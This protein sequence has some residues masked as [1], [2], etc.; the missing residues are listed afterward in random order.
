MVGM[1]GEKIYYKGG[2]WTQKMIE[3]QGEL[4]IDKRCS[5]G[6]ILKVAKWKVWCCANPIID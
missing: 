4:E 5:A 2:F 1:K 3:V 6:G